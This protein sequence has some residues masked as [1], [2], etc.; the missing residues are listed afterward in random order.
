MRTVVALSLIL[1]LPLAV[2]CSRGHAA[3]PSDTANGKVDT[4]LPPEQQAKQEAVRKMFIGFQTGTLVPGVAIQGR[5]EQILNEATRTT[6]WEFNG[7]PKGDEVPVV[8]H[9]DDKGGGPTNPKNPKKV[10]RVF[11]VT[12]GG[13][14]FK[15]TRK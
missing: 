2:G 5:S 11:L 15:I 1:A 6:S 12:G 7:P 14:L 3:G 13:D 9:F 4:S 10:D 8:L